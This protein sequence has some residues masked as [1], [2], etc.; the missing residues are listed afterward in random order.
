MSSDSNTIIAQRCTE[1]HTTTIISSIICHHDRVRIFF[2][3]GIKTHFNVLIS[4]FI[5]FNIWIN[6]TN[7]TGW[8]NPSNLRNID[9]SITV[10]NITEVISVLSIE[11]RQHDQSIILD[12][13]FKCLTRRSI[14]CPMNNRIFR[15]SIFHQSVIFIFI[16]VV[17]SVYK[18][19]INSLPF[20]CF[21]KWKQHRRQFHRNLILVLTTK[22]FKS[23][24]FQTSCSV[25]FTIH[26][27]E[28]KLVVLL[29]ICHMEQ[30][31]LNFCDDNIIVHIIFLLYI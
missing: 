7:F 29:K 13:D 12:C 26:L 27:S 25:K 8:S 4:I 24:I 11:N 19:R 18:K 10:I 9:Y 16:R 14:R 22:N 31:I 20:T 1:D 3:V 17:I 23:L 30:H 21:D 5:H 28:D 15:I 6:I 2:I